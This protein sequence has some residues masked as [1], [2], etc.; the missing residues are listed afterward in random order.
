MLHIAS[1]GGPS[2]LS[3]KALLPNM[4]GLCKASSIISLG[5]GN[6]QQ[7]RN[8]RLTLTKSLS[9]SILKKGAVKREGCGKMWVGGWVAGDR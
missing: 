6:K 8:V 1:S 2:A 9:L 3:T 7:G 4:A 5:A